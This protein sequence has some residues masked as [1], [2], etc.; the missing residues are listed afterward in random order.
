M[1]LP[2]FD[3]FRRVPHREKPAIRKMVV[4]AIRNGAWPLRI[5]TTFGIGMRTIITWIKK[6][7]GGG[8][9]ALENR[10]KQGRPRIPDEMHLQ[11]LLRT[12]RDSNSLQLKFEFACRTLKLIRQALV[13]KFGLTLG[14]STVR[15]A[16][17]ALGLSPQKPQVQACQRDEEAFEKWKNEDFPRTK[18]NSLKEG[19]VILFEDEAGIAANDH[20]GT[21]WGLRGKTPRAELNGARYRV[22]MLGAIGADGRLH[23]ELR[24][25]MSTSETFIGFLQSIL[26]E[27]GTKTFIITDNLSMQK[28]NKMK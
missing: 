21:T 1:K 22:S 16:L 20:V 18:K 5:S 11:W 3:D 8:C 9:K 2:A 24:E 6:F 12:V 19:A 28:S 14:V 10:S 27:T 7:L 17:R 25:G 23:Y 13:D 26:A 4:K 15:R